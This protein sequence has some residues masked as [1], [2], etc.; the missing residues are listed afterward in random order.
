MPLRIPEASWFGKKYRD[1]FHGTP[2]QVDFVRV[3]ASRGSTFAHHDTGLKVIAGAA[4]SLLEGPGVAVFLFPVT[5]YLCP[6]FSPNVY[7]GCN[8]VAASRAVLVLDGFIHQISAICGKKFCLWC[9]F[10][11]SLAAGS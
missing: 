9:C 11:D 3:P 10:L 1:G 6:R 2:G 5:C 8:N 7:A 4:G